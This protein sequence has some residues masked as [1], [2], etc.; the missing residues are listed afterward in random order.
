MAFGKRK[1]ETF[2]ATDYR[3]QMTVRQCIESAKTSEVREA[4]RQASEWAGLDTLATA[5][6]RASVA[7]IIGELRTGKRVH[8][9]AD[10]L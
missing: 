8:V 2:N 3:A 10:L 1:A 9:R 4:F 5:E 6:L 7:E